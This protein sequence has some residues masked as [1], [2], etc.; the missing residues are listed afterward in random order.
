M[1]RI[2]PRRRAAL[3]VA[4]AAALV[5]AGCTAEKK[6]DAKA[7]GAPAAPPAAKVAPGVTD[8]AIKIGVVYPDLSSVKQFMKIDHGDYEAAYKAVIGRIND[9]GGINGRKIVPVFGAVNVA[10]PAAAQ[11]TCVKLTQDEKVFA[12]VGTLNANEPLCYAQTNKTAVV[13]GP[14]TAKNYAE[15]QAPWFATE[16]GGDEVGDSV[17]L[18]TANNALAGKKVA[19]IGVVNEQSLVNEIVVPSLQKQ[20]VTPVETAIMDASFRDPAAVSQQLGVFIQKFQASGADTVVVVGG[21]GGEFPKQLEKTS[22]RPRLLFTGFN[23]AAT[24]T[25]DAA[26]H[27]FD[28]VLKDAA[29]LTAATKWDEPTNQACLTDIETRVPELK[30]KLTVDPA[31]MPA[32][33]PTPQ[34]SAGSA[35]LYLTL[36]QAIADK[37]GKDLTYESFQNAGFT[38]GPLQLPGFVDKADYTRQTPHG[39]IPMHLARYSPQQKKFVL[40]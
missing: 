25:G 11:E 33:E 21:M 3:L 30:G 4:A 2:R 24:Y 10:S 35:C 37:A 36:F 1:E 6:D 28:G 13:G 26:A 34:T 14:L 5:A 20:G 31:T 40:P 7:S 8:D 23:Q 9:A 38:L 16:R 22:Y 32:G 12:V 27:D 17:D 39:A 19:V 18:F 15:A 29:A